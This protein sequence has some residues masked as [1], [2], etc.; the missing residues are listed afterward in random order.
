[1]YRHDPFRRYVRV[2]E[3]YG[4]IEFN[5]FQLKMMLCTLNRHFVANFVAFKAFFYCWWNLLK[6]KCN[7]V[8]PTLILNESGQ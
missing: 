1:M 3:N 2:C 5:Y 8:G 4:Q 6:A 7:E